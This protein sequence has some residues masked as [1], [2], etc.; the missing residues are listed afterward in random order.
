MMS[1]FRSK[2]TKAVMEKAYGA[3]ATLSGKCAALAA[4]A[5]VAPVDAEKKIIELLT[6]WKTEWN[7]AWN[8]DVKQ[9][10][11][12]T[13]LPSLYR[14]MLALRSAIAE[15]PSGSGLPLLKKLCSSLTSNFEAEAL[16]ATG[17]WADNTAARAFLVS[18]LSA[19]DLPV[20]ISA[21]NLLGFIGGTSDVN[22]LR[23]L[24]NCPSLALAEAAACSAAMI[25]GISEGNGELGAKKR[26]DEIWLRM[27]SPVLSPESRGGKLIGA[28][29]DASAEFF[30]LAG[31]AIRK[32]AG[33]NSKTIA[34]LRAIMS[35]TGRNFACMG[36]YHRMFARHNPEM[37]LKGSYDSLK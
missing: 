4:L 8:G 3:S 21:A 12:S 16:S 13:P 15:L 5:R 28:K 2:K 23:K 29:V 36:D 35:G 10:Y 37:T 24:K 9:D 1:Y 26:I 27:P 34:M 32:Y 18:R 17:W 25:A 19:K 31:L 11:D 14:S 6:Q 7:R 33:D 22:E 30:R 20:A